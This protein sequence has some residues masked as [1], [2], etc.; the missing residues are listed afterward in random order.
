[1]G[2]FHVVMGETGWRRESRRAQDAEEE[3]A[4]PSPLAERPRP[5]SQGLTLNFTDAFSATIGPCV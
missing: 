1:M 2:H 5:G 3:G 4:G